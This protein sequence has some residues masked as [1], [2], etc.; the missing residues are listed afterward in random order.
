MCFKTSTRLVLLPKKN[1][2]SVLAYIQS[3][4]CDNRAAVLE[5]NISH[6]NF[7]KFFRDTATP[8]NTLPFMQFVFML[9]I[10]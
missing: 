5:R 3:P 7:S 4:D 2:K 6:R 9:V 10:I 1:K 8:K